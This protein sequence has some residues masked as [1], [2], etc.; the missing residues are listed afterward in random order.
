MRND[1]S[2]IRLTGYLL[3]LGGALR[4]TAFALSGFSHEGPGLAPVGL[5]FIAMG[6]GLLRGWRWLAYLT[7]LVVG[8]GVSFVIRGF[9]WTP[10]VPGY[11]L[12][13]IIAVDIAVV[14]SLLVHLWKNPRRSGEA[15]S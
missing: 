12:A 14:L 11:W 6:F 8:I 15:R 10:V 2:L 3:M 4:V 9:F 5:V 1:L 13:L 7:Y